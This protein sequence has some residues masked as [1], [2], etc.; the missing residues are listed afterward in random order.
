MICVP[1]SSWVCTGGALGPGELQRAGWREGGG[2]FR[3]HRFAQ[4]KRE[5][6]VHKHVLRWIAVRNALWR[7]GLMVYAD[8]LSV[9]PPEMSV[10]VPLVEGLDLP[11][12]LD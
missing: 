8:V 12:G 6:L 3:E 7:C 2:G 5:A 10:A 1:L 4:T 9:A 11:S